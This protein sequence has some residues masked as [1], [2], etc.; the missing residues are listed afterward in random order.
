MQ[1]SQAA[2]SASGF[3]HETP[4]EPPPEVPESSPVTEPPSA[5]TTVDVPHSESHSL[6]GA[7]ASAAAHDSLDA[8]S[9]RHVASEQSHLARHASAVGQLELRLESSDVHLLFTHA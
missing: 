8:Q 6:Q 9:D 5:S 4:S 1:L 2:S 3:R 7:A